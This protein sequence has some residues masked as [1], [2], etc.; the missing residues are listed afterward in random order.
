MKETGDYKLAFADPVTYKSSLLYLSHSMRQI[1]PAVRSTCFR[2]TGSVWEGETVTLSRTQISLMAGSAQ[3]PTNWLYTQDGGPE[4]RTVNSSYPVSTS[5]IDRYPVVSSKL[6]RDERRRE[7]LMLV[8]FA[9][10][11]LPLLSSDCSSQR[12]SIPFTA[13]DALIMQR[14]LIYQRAIIR[15]GLE[16]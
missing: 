8:E 7:H 4:R 10:F 5:C 13:D 14:I 11:V 2:C 1:L 12:C 3:R 9:A 16:N 6:A 15:L